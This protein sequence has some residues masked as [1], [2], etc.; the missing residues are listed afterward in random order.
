MPSPQTTRARGTYAPNASHQ[1][2]AVHQCGA[3]RS[4]SKNETLTIDDASADMSSSGEAGGMPALRTTPLSLRSFGHERSSNGLVACSPHPKTA[5]TLPSAVFG[6]GGWAGTGYELKSA[7]GA[8]D[9][10]N[11]WMVGEHHPER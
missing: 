10:G 8:S 5:E 6:N 3:C 9:V 11:S 2:G 7:L 4:K 1:P